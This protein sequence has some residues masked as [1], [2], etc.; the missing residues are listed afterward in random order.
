MV[1]TLVCGGVSSVFSFLFL[2]N[3]CFRIHGVDIAELTGQ[4]A[5]RKK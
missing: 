1:L 2:L 3:A 5:A 4:K